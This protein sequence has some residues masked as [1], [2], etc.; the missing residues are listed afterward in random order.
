MVPVKR[1]AV[2]A[3]RLALIAGGLIV[4]A[5][6]VSELASMPEPPPDSDGFPQGMALLF[7]T[8]FAVVAVGA[9]GLGVA[10]PALL[11]T[12]DPL[13]F[14]RHQRLGLKAAGVLIAGGFV[15]G[16][17]IAVA[18]AF[19]LGVVLWLL[20]ILVAVLLILVVLAWRLVEAGIG[21]VRTA[22]G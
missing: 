2:A 10:L 12:D 16:V 19:E 6:I 13:G 15:L 7:G 4:A 14:S 3:V 22:I 18:S 17:A 9:A 20:A 1:Y 11:G 5:G 8:V 21:L